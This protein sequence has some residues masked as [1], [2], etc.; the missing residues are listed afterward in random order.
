MAACLCASDQKVENGR[1]MRVVSWNMNHWQ[2]SRGNAD[3]PSKGWE[4]LRTSLQ[5]DVALVQEAALP[6]EFEPAGYVGTFDDDANRGWGTG[7]VDLTD[8]GIERFTTFASPDRS[9]QLTLSQSVPGAAAARR[10]SA[11]GT[12]A[13]SPSACTGS[14]LGVA[15]TQAC[16]ATRPTLPPF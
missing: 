16:F 4:Y 2:Q 6:T 13:S 5:A 8:V 9:S 11:E 12:T 7:I 15:A 10:T 3:S 14:S 1:V